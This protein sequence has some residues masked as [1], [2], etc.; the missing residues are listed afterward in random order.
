[1]EDAWIGKVM[2]AGLIGLVLWGI[3]ALLQARSEAARRARI[4][5]GG[6]F[7]LII[8]WIV[9]MI[10]GPVG[11]IIALAIIGAGVWIVKGSKS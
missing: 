4:V 10:V 11:F 7:A 9:F 2:A 1:M 3:T 6:A 8:A 5:I